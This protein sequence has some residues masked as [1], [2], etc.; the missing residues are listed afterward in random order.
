M[1][2]KIYLD[3][4]YNN[5][6]N[7]KIK[8]NINYVKNII[9]EIC[10]KNNIK[11]IPIKLIYSILFLIK[12]KINFK[13]INNII[14]NKILYK[15]YY[16]ISKLIPNII[17]TKWFNIID[18]AI[19]N[20]VQEDLINYFLFIYKLYIK[21]ENCPNI[22]IIQAKNILKKNIL[23]FRQLKNIFMNEIYYTIYYIDI[24]FSKIS[25]NYINIDNIFIISNNKN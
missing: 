16:K 14:Y 15:T 18:I 6:Y 25:I 9:N 5:K 17:Y 19:I 12:N 13:L 4:F 8:I 22:Y 2:F 23:Y 1:P 10:V 11:Y 7:L 24:I 21:E 3:D 20:N